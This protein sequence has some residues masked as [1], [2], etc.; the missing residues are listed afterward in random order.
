[1][2]HASQAKDAISNASMPCPMEESTCHYKSH[3]YTR[4]DNAEFRVSGGVSAC[5]SKSIA[6]GP[7]ADKAQISHS[8]LQSQN[9][10]GFHPATKGNSVSFDTETENHKLRRWLDC[11]LPGEKLILSRR[12]PVYG[13]FLFW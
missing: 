1:M 13:D 2:N 4:D 9:S 3:N 8:F 11:R 7:M 10:A 5:A 6:S 12:I